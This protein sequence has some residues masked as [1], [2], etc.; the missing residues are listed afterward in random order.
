MSVRFSVDTC[1]H[2]PADEGVARTSGVR[3]NNR[4]VNDKK[5]FH[6]LLTRFHWLLMEGKKKRSSLIEMMS[7]SL[8]EGELH[9]T[10]AFD[11]LVSAGRT[12]L[13]GW[14]D[15]N[16]LQP[17]NMLVLAGTKSERFSDFSSVV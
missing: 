2:S 15:R 4:A 5:R 13:A 11:G 14:F 7:R 8:G 3:V 17:P 1:R 16:F 12:G 10:F 9:R 6:W